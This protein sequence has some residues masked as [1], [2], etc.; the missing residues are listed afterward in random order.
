MSDSHIS[1]IVLMWKI[2]GWLTFINK[3]YI[4]IHFFV[5]PFFQGHTYL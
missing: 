5:N 3:H 2:C 1:K 4:N